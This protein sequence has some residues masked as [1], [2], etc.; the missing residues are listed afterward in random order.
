M[1]LC[2]PNT[3]KICCIQPFA[4]VSVC[5]D[6]TFSPALQL[7]Q[8]TKDGVISSRTS[9]DSISGYAVPLASVSVTT[10]SSLA[11]GTPSVQAAG[12]TTSSR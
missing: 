3:F 6:L 7:L 12:A 8:I 1:F 10:K 2:E 11:A 5:R 4:C 9:R